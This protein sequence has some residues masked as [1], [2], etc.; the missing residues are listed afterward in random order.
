M[1]AII[2]AQTERLKLRQWEKADFPGFASINADPDVM[3]YYPNVLSEAQSNAMAQK[4]ESLIDAR[5]W[6]FWAV[7]KT[8]DQQFIGFV[9]LHEPAYDLPVT[10]CVE[11][12]WRLGKEYW[13]NGYATEAAIACLEIAFKRLH[14][15]EVYSFT[16]VS[17][18]KSQA[19]ME[20]IGMVNTNKNFEHPMIP[21]NHPLREHY[22]Y[23]AD[24]ESWGKGV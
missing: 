2:E 15:P 12:G 5:G 19:V 24:R 11:I 17:N 10:P 8:D 4:F 7:E 16:P 18:K 6:G 22:L 9:G 21:E 3:K 23:K 20:R 14:I 13:G 1:A